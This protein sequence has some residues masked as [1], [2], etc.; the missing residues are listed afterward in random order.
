MRIPI[1]I[2]VSLKTLALM[3]LTV[4]VIGIG[5]IEV[6]SAYYHLINTSLLTEPISSFIYPLQTS[7]PVG[8]VFQALA[9]ILYIAF[10]WLVIMSIIAGGIEMA[11]AGASGILNVFGIPIPRGTSTGGFRTI[12]TAIVAW[13]IVNILLESF[14]VSFPPPISLIPISITSLTISTAGMIIGLGTGLVFVGIELY[15]AIN[16]LIEVVI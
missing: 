16:D 13:E 9:D 1:S 4:M 8:S 14:G 11:T 5:A 7:S 2:G 15:Y 3:A 6:Y 10:F 12:F